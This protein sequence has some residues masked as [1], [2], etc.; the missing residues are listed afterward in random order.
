MAVEV[1]KYYE[2]LLTQAGVAEDKRQALLNALSDEAVAKALADDSIAPRLRHD[3]FSRN[4]DAL[5]KDKEQWTDFYKKTLT[6]HEQNQKVVQDYATELE[7][8]RAQVGQDP[9]VRPPLTVATPGMTREQFDQ[10]IQKRDQ[11]YLTLLETGLTL[12][13]RHVH[14]FKEPLDVQ[15]LK[16]IAIEKNLSLSQAYD[17]MV[18]PK[19][20][21]FNQTQRTEEIARAKEEAVKEFASKNRIPIDVRPKEGYSPLLD[22]DRT[23][24]VEYDDKSRRLTRT[25]E[26]TLRQNF[27]EAFNSGSA[28]TSGGSS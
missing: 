8:L 12:A 7:Q 22:Q 28:G 5:K 1:S 4:M 6:T 14:E 11:N 25:G 2:G 18:K 3:E 15:G 19:R 13:T 21:A 24:Q 16:Q 27:V 10:E 9:T 17:E 20:D 26:Q 23:K